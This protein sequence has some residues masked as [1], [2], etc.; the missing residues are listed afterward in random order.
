MRKWKA[1]TLIELL[2]VISIIALLIGIL[3]PALGAAR[4]TAR[5]MQSNTQVRGIQQAMVL[6]AQGNNGYYP[7]M[8]S[9]G[10]LEQDINMSGLDG[11]DPGARY[12]LMLQGNF[13][14]GEYCISPVDVK[15]EWTSDIADSGQYSYAILDI[16]LAP[17]QTEWRDTINTEAIVICDRNIS[18]VANEANVQ[19][20]WTTEKGDW[21]GSIGWND[22]HTTFETKAHDDNREENSYK[23]KYGTNINDP[24]DNP[25]TGDNLF[26]DDDESLGDAFMIFGAPGLATESP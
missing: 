1:F 2:V 26:E 4:R 11:D 8:N 23:T 9:R 22:N 13:F 17:E 10:G 20:I 6:F 14:T 19:S 5:Q 15:I 12:T 18:D 7:G 3:L 16:S 24:D 25:P 21:R